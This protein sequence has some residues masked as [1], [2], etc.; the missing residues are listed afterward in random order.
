M[1]TKLDIVLLVGWLAS[2]AL[3]LESHGRV[4][5]ASPDRVASV[6]PM[7]CRVEAPASTFRPFGFDMAEPSP[8][9]IFD[10]ALMDVVIRCEPE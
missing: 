4:D 3:A 7:N 8:Q 9:G 1:V 5:T 2:G 6:K 10:V